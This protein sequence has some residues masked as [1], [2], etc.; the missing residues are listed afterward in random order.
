MDYYL[1]RIKLKNMSNIDKMIIGAEQDENKKR[2]VSPDASIKRFSITD[3]ITLS[4]GDPSDLDD[5]QKW[6]P[7]TPA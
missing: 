1:G 2:Y 5:G 7:L 4:E 3:V 6:G